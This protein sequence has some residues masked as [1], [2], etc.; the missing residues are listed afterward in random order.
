MDQCAKPASQEWGPH[1]NSP[2]SS[3][4]DSSFT[5]HD[6]R[7]QHGSNV[8]TDELQF[9]FESAIG[10]VSM[11]SSGQTELD[12]LDPTQSDRQMRSCSVPTV[13]THPRQTHL[14]QHSARHPRRTH[15]RYCSIV[16][17]NDEILKPVPEDHERLSLSMDKTMK[18]SPKKAQSQKILKK[19]LCVKKSVSAKYFKN[20]K[21]RLIVLRPS[22]I[23][24][25][26]RPAV[27]DLPCT[28]ALGL[29]SLDAM[30]SVEVHET[31]SHTLAVETDGQRLL[32]RTESDVEMTS[33]VWA[34]TEC[35]VK[36]NAWDNE[37]ADRLSDL[38]EWEGRTSSLMSN[39][40]SN[41]F[42]Q[43]RG[44]HC[45]APAWSGRVETSH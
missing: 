26:K 43:N 9:L 28:P 2:E 16:S 29:L 41:P 33:W 13:G 35:I 31:S 18:A 42:T 6:S 21:G 30:S 20:W 32:L 15:E 39:G 14:C 44:R 36:L 7:I 8:S 34:I 17:L 11:E 45:S 25:H 3:L 12:D 19:G 40:K 23:F 27:G 22:G 24:W 1:L 4:P 10:Q 37:F 5:S 38:N